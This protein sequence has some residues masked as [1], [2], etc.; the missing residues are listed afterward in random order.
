MIFLSF[1]FRFSDYG[2]FQIPL[3][4]PN[5]NSSFTSCK[6]RRVMSAKCY[7]GPNVDLQFLSNFNSLVILQDDWKVD[8]PSGLFS[9]LLGVRKDLREG[10]G[11]YSRNSVFWMIKIL[12]SPHLF[13]Q[14][15]HSSTKVSRLVEEVTE[16]EKY[17]L[18]IL[19]MRK[20][21]F[22]PRALMSTSSE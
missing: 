14:G 17:F 2:F 13:Q 9:E 12:V 19:L 18:L 22:R 11:S 10:G 3:T 6:V 21:F 1:T 16:L 20:A 5:L 15:N 7:L 4:K 8:R